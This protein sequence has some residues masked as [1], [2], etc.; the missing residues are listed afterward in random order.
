MNN[1]IRC[2]ARGVFAAKDGA[3]SVILA[4]GGGVP[5]LCCGRPAYRLPVC[6][7]CLRVQLHPEL[8]Q[9][10][11][12]RLCG[13]ELL[14]EDGL[15]MEC[16]RAPVFSAVT[17]AFP[18][19]PYV[20]W[21]RDLLYAWKTHGE[22]GL[23][24]VFARELYRL[25]RAEEALHCGPDVLPVVPVPPRP[26]KLRMHGWDQ[27]HDLAHALECR[28]GAAV[29]H[30]LKRTGG[31]QQKT[32]NRAER[33][34]RLSGAYTLCKKR[35]PSVVP[36]AVILLD[37][38]MTTGATLESCARELKTAGVETVYAVAVAAVP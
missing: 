30:M 37:D 33:L 25:F 11:R 8:P 19:F 38:I 9:K 16:R 24:G 18:L 28:W 34:S 3:R 4:A 6:G 15:C 26:G 29:H 20:F 35:V 5:C 23:S 14:S 1:I 10:N 27:V 2:A 13:R 17:R 12:C 31:A 21:Y 36:Q 22:R 32:Q 7:S